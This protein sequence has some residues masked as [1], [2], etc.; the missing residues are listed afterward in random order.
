MGSDDTVGSAEEGVI[1]KHRFDADD[2]GAVAAQ[3]SAVQSGSDI[4]LVNDGASC[5]VKK[6]GAGLKK[7]QG[8]PVDHPACLICQRAVHGNDIGV[9]DTLFKF[10]ASDSAAVDIDQGTDQ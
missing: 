8:F 3:K 9:P 6:N 2:V 10:Q 4:S 1:R 7:S 5:N